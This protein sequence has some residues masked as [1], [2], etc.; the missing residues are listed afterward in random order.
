MI[1]PSQG[2]FRSF[3]RSLLTNVPLLRKLI[4]M[5]AKSTSLLHALLMPMPMDMCNRAWAATEGWR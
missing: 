1:I 3:M 4:A 2:R 5:K